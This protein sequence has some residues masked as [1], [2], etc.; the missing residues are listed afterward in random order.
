MCG[1]LS[2]AKLALR[3]FFT[4]S[5]LVRSVLPNCVNICCQKPVQNLSSRRGVSL[6]ILCISYGCLWQNNSGELNILMLDQKN[7]FGK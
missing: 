7:N 1:E 5:S 6:S 4:K 3:A 2:L